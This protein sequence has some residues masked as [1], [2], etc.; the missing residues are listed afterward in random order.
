MIIL[1]EADS[2]RMHGMGFTRA[3]LC[4][5]PT[6]AQEFW[7]EILSQESFPVEGQGKKHSLSYSG[8]LTVPTFCPAS[9]RVDPTL[10][11][12]YFL[13]TC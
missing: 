10:G 13:F 9:S 8:P 1:L 11:P 7:T 2:Q 6:G 5:G 4:L 12:S 3:G